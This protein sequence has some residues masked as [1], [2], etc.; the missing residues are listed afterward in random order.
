MVRTVAGRLL[1]TGRVGLLPGAFDPP[2][3]AHVAIA[4]IAQRRFAL[5]QVVFVLS[6][7]MPHK[8]IERP[9]FDERLRWLSKIAGERPDRAATACGVGLVIDIVQAFRAELGPA[10]EFFVIAGKDAAERYAGWDYGDGMLFADQLRHYRLL[11]ASRD[12]N[13]RVPAQH[14]GRILPFGIDARYDAASSSAVRAAVRSGAR[15]DHIVP[16]AI[17]NAVGAAYGEV[18]T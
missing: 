12:G 3:V 2:T 1:A 11:V 16:A 9:G 5:D 4:D 14:A 18:R 7:A 6:E 10:C 13:Y 15:W 17:R 8:R